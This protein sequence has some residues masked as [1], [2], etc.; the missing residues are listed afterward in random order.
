MLWTIILII[1]AIF[2]PPLAVFLMSGLG[3]D[4]WINLILTILFWA[5]GVIHAIFLALTRTEART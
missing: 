5:P 2:I 1:I 4:F 3:R